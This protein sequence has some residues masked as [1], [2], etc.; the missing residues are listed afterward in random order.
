MAAILNY[1]HFGF[2]MVRMSNGLYQIRIF[3]PGRPPIK[4]GRT[5][6]GAGNTPGTLQEITAQVRSEILITLTEKSNPSNTVAVRGVGADWEDSWTPE[7][8]TEVATFFSNLSNNDIITVDFVR[9][10]ARIEFSAHPGV[11]EADFEIR[12]SYTG[13][14]FLAKTEVPEATVPL[15]VNAPG[16]VHIEFSAESGTPETELPLR[17]I[18]PPDPVQLEFEAESEI[19]TAFMEIDTATK[20]IVGDNLYAINGTAFY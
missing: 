11:P 7:N 6:Q 18:D 4:G 13:I 3:S 5:V 17:K 9:A 16:D 14:E 15:S 19:P 1:P 10:V 2:L 12:E 8:A 20:E